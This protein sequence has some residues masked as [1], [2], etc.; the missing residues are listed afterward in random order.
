MYSAALKD[1]TPEDAREFKNMPVWMVWG[2]KEWLA[3]VNRKL[4]D[5]FLEAGVNLKWAEVEGVGHR[6]LSEYQDDLMD[7]FL[8]QN[9]TVN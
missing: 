4:K 9:K 6:Y 2:E 3:D 5:Y 8:K 1:V 7:W